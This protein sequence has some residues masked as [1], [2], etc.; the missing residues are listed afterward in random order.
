MKFHFCIGDSS[1]IEWCSL[2]RKVCKDIMEK[3]KIGGP[4]LQ[5]ELSRTFVYIRKY[6]ERIH[7]YKMWCL[8]GICRES[9]TMFVIPIRTGNREAIHTLIR[10]FVEPLSFIYTDSWSAYTGIEMNYD[11]ITSL[12][13]GMAAHFIINSSHKFEKTVIVTHPIT[14]EEVSVICNTTKIERQWI[15]LKRSI[16]SC[17][18]LATDKRNHAELYIAEFIYRRE[19]LKHLRGHCDEMLKQ[20]LSD[21]KT[22]YPALDLRSIYL[23]SNPTNNHIEIEESDIIYI[24]HAD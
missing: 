9:N 16:K 12:G 7:K 5:V 18:F 21:I 13:C 15:Q 6:Q 2:C 24:V 3:R 19:C 10:Q 1:L 23:S 22:I 14:N 4:G 8:G 17:S 11:P 20:F